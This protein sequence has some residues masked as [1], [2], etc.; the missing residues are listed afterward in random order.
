MVKETIAGGLLPIC[1]DWGG[2]HL[3]I[4]HGK[5]RFLAAPSRSYEIPASLAIC[6]IAGDTRLVA[7]ISGNARARASHRDWGAVTREW[8]GMYA[9]LPA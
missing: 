5:S 3:L 4:E 2:R 7:E 9:T 1:F 6:R 8:L